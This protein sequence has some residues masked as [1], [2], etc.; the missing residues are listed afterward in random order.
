MPKKTKF[1]ST[2]R[3]SWKS[4]KAQ[5]DP[6]AIK[7][8]DFSDGLGPALDKLQKLMDPLYDEEEVSDKSLRTV[9]TSVENIQKIIKKYRD[10]IVEGNNDSPELGPSWRNLHQALLRL[11]ENL[12]DEAKELG[13]AAKKLTGWLNKSAFQQAPV[14]GGRKDEVDL[15]D[16]VNTVLRKLDPKKGD[17]AE[18]LKILGGKSLGGCFPHSATLA[19]NIIREAGV[20]RGALTFITTKLKEDPPKA[21]L[22][23]ETFST[24]EEQL[25]KACRLLGAYADPLEDFLQKHVLQP[26]DALIEEAT[27]DAN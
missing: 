24:L 18:I 9:A 7:A 17:P 13:A 4:I 19:E 15:E 11:D 23:R 5:C 21:E 16:N 12:V 8:C 22:A 6:K 14:E 20:A 26:V 25:D 2:Y 3:A 10:Q 1:V 27:E